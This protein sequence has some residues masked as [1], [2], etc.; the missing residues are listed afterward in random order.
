MPSVG[1]RVLERISREAAVKHYLRT[2]GNG[3]E[4]DQSV[5]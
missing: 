3:A 4:G 2:G 5:A 1:L